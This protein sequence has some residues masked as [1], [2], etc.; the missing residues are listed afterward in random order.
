MREPLRRALTHT[1]LGLEINSSFF[2]RNGKSGYLLKPEPLRNKALKEMLDR[3]VRY[4]LDVTVRSS[5]S[6]DV[7]PTR[8]S[9]LSS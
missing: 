3:S 9:L 8:S 4:E 6:V 2:A 7:K 5:V 1:D